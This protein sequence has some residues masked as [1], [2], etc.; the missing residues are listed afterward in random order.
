MNENPVVPDQR[1]WLRLLGGVLF[2]AGCVIVYFREQATDGFA[3]FPLLLVVLIPCALLLGLGLT[4]GIIAPAQPGVAGPRIAPWPWQSVYLVF[5]IL[6]IPVVLLQFV[7]TIKGTPND[8]WNIVWVF[9]VTAGAALFASFQRGVRY[10]AFLGGLALLVSWLAFWDQVLGDPSAN[11]VRWLLLIFAVLVAVAALALWGSWQPQGVEYLTVAG[12]AI[13]GVGLISL[14]EL[15]EQVRNLRALDFEGAGP[16]GFWNFILLASA[17]ALIGFAAR[18]GARGPGYVGAFV[19]FV[20]ISIVAFDLASLVEGD[21]PSGSF[22]VW[23]ILMLLFGALGIAASF[24]MPNGR[25]SPA[26]GNGGT[27]PESPPPG[28]VPGAG[29]TP[30]AT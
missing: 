4:T 3:R 28:S 18:T 26:P 30:P 24:F 29:T 21:D 20:F 27:A 16:N 8:G 9:L 23:D 1:D 14:T 15:A 10:T 19:L 13:L 22:G 25:A 12:L 17:L 11:T 2:A 6:L 7:D 5:G